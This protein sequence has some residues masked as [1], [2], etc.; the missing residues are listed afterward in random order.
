MADELPFFKYHL[1]PMATGV[2]KAESTICPVCAQRRSHVYVGPFYSVEEVEGICPWCIHNGAAAKKYDG[3]FQDAASC[4]PV[5]D[6]ECF[7]ELTERTPGYSGWQQESWLSHC[8]D[9]CAFVGYPDWD[10][11]EPLADE[12]HSDIERIKED[13]DLDDD[14]FVDALDAGSLAAYLFKCIHCGRHRIAFD[15]D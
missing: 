15:T 14:E 8:G 12:L 5:S 10:K 1:D 4:E 13:M 11:V 6:P 9:F 7:I 2:I 3:S